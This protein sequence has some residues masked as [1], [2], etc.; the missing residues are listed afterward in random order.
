MFRKVFDEWSQ[1]GVGYHQA[2]RLFRLK[3]KS[4][5]EMAVGVQWKIVIVR[6]AVYKTI[7][8]N[9]RMPAHFGNKTL[10]VKEVVCSKPQQLPK[11]PLRCCVQKRAEKEMAQDIA[12]KEGTK[13]IRQF[14][15][16]VRS[17]LATY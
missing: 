14:K 1:K 10:F 13:A 11:S 6:K 7:P 5:S 16:W 2:S 15:K 17:I 4:A 12:I 8:K 3:R 9:L